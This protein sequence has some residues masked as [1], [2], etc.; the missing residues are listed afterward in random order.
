MTKR[1]QIAWALD[2]LGVSPVPSKKL[3]EPQ[4]HSTHAKQFAHF[5]WNL[6]KHLSALALR[7]Q[8]LALWNYECCEWSSQI[9]QVLANL[10]LLKIFLG[11]IN[12]EPKKVCL[13]IKGLSTNFYKGGPKQNS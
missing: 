5:N 9:F 11:N 6:Q 4:D 7:V 12:K 3:F 13:T 8:C 1:S 2:V 10:I